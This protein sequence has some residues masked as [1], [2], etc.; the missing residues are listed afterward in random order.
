M[1]VRYLNPALCPEERVLDL[2]PRMSV[3]EKVSQMVQI[4][5]NRVTLEEAENWVSRKYAGSFLHVLGDDARHLQKLTEKT[6]LGIPLLFGID[7]IHGHALHNGATVFPSQLAMSCSWNKELVEEA[8]RVTAREVSADGLHWTFSPVLCIGRDLRWG[9]INETFG[10]DPY[11]IGELAAAIIKGYQGKNLSDEDSILACAKHY[12]AYGESTGG[13]DSY[14]TEISHRKLREVFLPPFKEAVKAGCATFMAGYQSIDG[15]PVSANKK[16]LKDILKEELGF[17]G[18]VVTDWENTRSLIVNQKIAAD[19]REASIKAVEAGNDMI[20][21]TPEFY[22]ETIKLVKEGI[23]PEAMI[24][25]AVKRI[26]YIKFAMGLFEVKR[27]IDTKAKL[28]VFA[29]K[30]H[31]ESN[32]KLTRESIVLLENKNNIL[33]LK[34]GIKKIAVIGPNADDIQAQF[35]DWTFFSHPDPKPDAVPVIEYYTMLRGITEEAGKRNIEVVYHKGC[36]IMDSLKEDITGAV[37]ISKEADII[38]LVLGDCLAQNGEFKDRANLE[39]SGSQN[40]LLKELKL[41]EKPIITVLVNGKPLAVSEVAQTSDALI[42]SF[43][44]GMFGGKAVAE[45]IFG[46]VNPSG[47]LSISFP[48]HSGQLPV[49]YNSLPGWHGGRYMDMPQEPLYRFGYGLSYT[50]FSYNNL[51]LSKAVCGKDDVITVKIQVTNTGEIHGYETVQLYV[52]DVVS[53]IVTPVEQ[54]KGFAKL[55]I[56]AG[57]T[58]EAEILLNISELVI[59]DSNE[60][61]VVEAGEFEIMAGGDS[62]EESLLK[63]MLVV[64]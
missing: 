54:L 15:I 25:E 13:R 50:A 19:I 20:M 46:E 31:L 44:S 11:L 32:L 41:L 58:A 26:L 29:C 48:Y 40:R 36:D 47:K 14:D 42:E 27:D 16:V 33:P 22:E 56:K 30:E 63:T 64:Q 52:R 55:Y 21:N 34:G 51:R 9:R 39:L 5:Y 10:E 6:P 17:N 18:F 3:E 45:I 59:V 7:A 43:N 53:S 38:I 35:G 49:Y 60:N 57:E 62:R 8:G 61:Y 4:S 23:I 28:E 1:D 2:L 37:N 24:D 12:I